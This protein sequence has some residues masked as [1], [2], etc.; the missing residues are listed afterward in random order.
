M[1]DAMT[2]E[3]PSLQDLPFTF[4]ALRAAYAAGLR[5]AEV[6]A[7]VDRKSVV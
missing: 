4:A 1:R 3:T 7:E 5:P 6:V 2:G